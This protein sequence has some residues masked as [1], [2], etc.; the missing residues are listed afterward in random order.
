MATERTKRILAKMRRKSDALKP[1][2]NYGEFDA[3]RDMRVEVESR[4]RPRCLIIFV[5][6]SRSHRRRLMQHI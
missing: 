2:V 5:T 3:R 1:A 6:P 4:P